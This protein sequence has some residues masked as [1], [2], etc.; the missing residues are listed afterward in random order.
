[1]FVDHV[2]EFANEMIDL[3]KSYECQGKNGQF[4]G[5]QVKK[6]IKLT[7]GQKN[8]NLKILV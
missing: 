7:L 8:L 4:I 1:M 2:K 5:P 6:Y 3:L